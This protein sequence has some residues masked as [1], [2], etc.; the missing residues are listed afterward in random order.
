MDPF[1]RKF[2]IQTVKAQLA[3]LRLE[4]A[5][6]V[7]KFETEGLRDEYRARMV[8]RL[9]NAMKESHALQM[10]LEQLIAISRGVASESIADSSLLEMQERVAVE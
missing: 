1:I 8:H 2:K 4:C 9:E 3:A 5:S 6:P 10:N 7:Q